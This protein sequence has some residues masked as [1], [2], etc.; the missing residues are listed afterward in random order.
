MPNSEHA[1]SERAQSGASTAPQ[2]NDALALDKETVRDLE[3]ATEDQIKGGWGGTNAC[4]TRA[5]GT[6]TGA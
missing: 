2:A 3:S 6:G 5:C 4:Q 1:P